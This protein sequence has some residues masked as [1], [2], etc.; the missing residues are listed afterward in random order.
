MSFASA[1]T[2]TRTVVATVIINTALA[3]IKV[4]AGVVGNSYALI[5]DGIESSLDVFTSFAVWGGLRMATKP[6]DANHPFGHGRAE[7]LSALVVAL[8]VI[9]AGIGIAVQSVREI[10]TPHLVPRP[11]TLIVLVLVVVVKEV[12]YRRIAKIGR[13]ANST[14]LGSEAWHQRSDA[15]TS[16][17]AF[18]GILIGVI[19]G[20]A[21]ASADDWAALLASGVIVTNGVRLLRVALAEVM[22]ETPA[23]HLIGGVRRAA[24]DVDGVSGIEKC[25][26]RKAGLTYLVDIHVEVDGQLPVWRGHE[27]AHAVVD[28]LKGETALNVSDVIVHIEPAPQINQLPENPARNI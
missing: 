8:V 25:R 14:S 17:A 18:I 3:L 11:F 23:K 4:T 10:L 7:S 24:G 16:A 13:E 15:I 5:A 20:D 2:A 27:I 1:T 26:V 12:L 6:P 21:Y 22:D 28:A 19:G 9:A